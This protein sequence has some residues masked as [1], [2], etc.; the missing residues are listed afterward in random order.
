[1]FFKVIRV[2][3]FALEWLGMSF[4]KFLLAYW[5]GTKLEV[6]FSSAK[7]FG[8]EAQSFLSSSY[9]FGTKLRVFS[10]LPNGSEK[11]TKHLYLPENGL[12]QNY[13]IQSAFL[14]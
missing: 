5:F 6:F 11:N 1:M 4:Q 12:E 9:W 8:T 10:L 14:F 3:F 7:W 2:F 13:T